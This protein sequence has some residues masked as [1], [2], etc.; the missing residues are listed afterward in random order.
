MA[1]F[2]SGNYCSRPLAAVRRRCVIGVAPP[3]PCR[4]SAARHEP[5]RRMRGPT[6]VCKPRPRPG[7]VVPR[8]ALA[9]ERGRSGAADDDD[10]NVIAVAPPFPRPRSFPS[11]WPGGTA[12]AARRHRRA[13]RTAVRGQPRSF[14][15]AHNAGSPAVSRRRSCSAAKRAGGAAYSQ[16]DVERASR[17]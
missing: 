2:L 11:R 10:G 13:L 15:A 3:F 9:A 5:A 17:G 4:G 16:F 7:A 8:G 14:S 6:I 12:R 1:A